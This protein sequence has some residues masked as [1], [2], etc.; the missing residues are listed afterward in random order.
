MG[1]FGLDTTHLVQ[2]LGCDWTV[3]TVGDDIKRAAAATASLNWLHPPASFSEMFTIDFV[4]GT[5]FMSHMGEAN[6]AMARRDKPVALVARP[7]PITRTR[8]RQ[9]ALVTTFEPGPAT[10]VTLT[11]GS[12]GLWRWIA[13]LVTIEDFGP[14]HS[15]CVPH[16]KI[17]PAEDVRAFLTEYGQLG[18]PHH[19]AICFGDARPRLRFAASLMNADYYEI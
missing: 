12:G 10:L 19:N 15:L 6:V 3:L 14:L 1:D 2:S 13:S 4:G 8:G 7:A 11:L 5:L 16:F 9:L 18:G 17:R